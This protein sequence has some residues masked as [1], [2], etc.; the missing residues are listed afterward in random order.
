MVGLPRA[1]NAFSNIH[2]ITILKLCCCITVL[3]CITLH[4][5]VLMYYTVLLKV[6]CASSN[7]RK[8]G[9]NTAAARAYNAENCNLQIF[10]SIL[11]RTFYI[12]DKCYLRLQEFNISGNCGQSLSAATF[13][14]NAVTHIIG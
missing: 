9:W 7:M 14:F 11:S 6:W 5:T 8:S 2:C 3:H 1:Y 4:Y 12:F 10:T 13:A